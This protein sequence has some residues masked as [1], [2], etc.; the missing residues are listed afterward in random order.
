MAIARCERC[1]RPRGANVKPP[2][3]ADAPFQPVGHPN[4]GIVCGKTG[5]EEPGLVR[6]KRDEAQRYLCGPRVFTIHTQAAKVRV[7]R[8]QGLGKQA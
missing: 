8:I 2:G 4:S 5:C 3:Y 6:L 7:Q 1:G